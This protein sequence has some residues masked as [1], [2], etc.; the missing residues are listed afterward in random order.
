VERAFGIER[1][2]LIHRRA[3]KLPLNFPRPSTAM[4]EKLVA[5]SAITSPPQSDE[6]APAHL[7]SLE[8]ASERRAARS[9]G[10]RWRRIA[11]WTGLVIFALGVALLAYVFWNAYNTLQEFSKPGYLNMQVNRIQ[12][13][14]GTGVLDAPNNVAKVLQATVVVFGSEILRVLYLLILG[15]IASALAARGIQFFAASESVID[16]AVVPED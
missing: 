12:D 11:R 1:Q 5:S 16:E 4:P 3:Q 2:E 7:P 9:A 6:L 10:V 14:P 15:F 13:S 8:Y